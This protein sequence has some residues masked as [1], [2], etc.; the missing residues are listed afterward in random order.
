MDYPWRSC[1]TSGCELWWWSVP[2]PGKLSSRQGPAELQQL[3]SYLNKFSESVYRRSRLTKY[4]WKRQKTWRWQSLFVGD[5]RL[6]T[7]LSSK[8]QAHGVHRD[9]CKNIL[10]NKDKVLISSAFWENKTLKK[11][12]YTYKS[13]LGSKLVLSN[14]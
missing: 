14:D 4:S 13:K 2:Q 7:R 1:R 3:S 11:Q 8:H 12:M 9:V 5:N 6:A 10:N